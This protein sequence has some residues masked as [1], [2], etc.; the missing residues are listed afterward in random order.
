M[1]DVNADINGFIM[2]ESHRII[3]LLNVVNVSVRNLEFL[4]SRDH[5]KV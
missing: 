5:N 3:A 1:I 2:S 4:I